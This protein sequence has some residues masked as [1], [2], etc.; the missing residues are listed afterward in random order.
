MANTNALY[1]AAYSGAL[2]GL[3]SRW[4][5]AEAFPSFE[6]A[7]VCATAFA[8]AVDDNLGVH[9]GLTQSYPDLLQ[10]ICSSFWEG[11]VPVKTE[12]EDYAEDVIPLCNLW[13][14]A[15]DGILATP[16]GG[17]A[18]FVPYEDFAGNTFEII[19]GE[20]DSDSFIIYPAD[21]G[22][23]PAGTTHILSH[24]FVQVTLDGINTFSVQYQVSFDGGDTWEGGSTFE[25]SQTGA[26]GGTFFFPI[27]S[28]FPIGDAT[29]ELPVE[30]RISVVGS[31]VANNPTVINVAQITAQAVIQPTD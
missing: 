15:V 8:T 13:N 24:A 14:L 21:Q 27:S 4:L 11:R 16:E 31:A 3:S 10:Q 12:A 28:S 9:E 19:V 26:G 22:A 18:P 6:N 23:F 5:T 7:I 20:V 29:G 1:N 2:S 30:G 17:G 25:F